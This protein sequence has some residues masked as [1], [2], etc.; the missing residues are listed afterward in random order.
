MT[1]TC[2]QHVCFLDVLGSHLLEAQAKARIARIGQTQPTTAWH[3]IARG[4]MDEL[5]R[6][7]A[8]A[9]PQVNPQVMP[10]VQPRD[11]SPGD[12]MAETA[13]DA[14]LGAKDVLSLLRRAI[15]LA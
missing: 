9:T 8:D 2:A 12:V 6:R 10:Q 13:Q 14:A 5:M 15:Q 11:G 7:A 4:S 1:L 3:L